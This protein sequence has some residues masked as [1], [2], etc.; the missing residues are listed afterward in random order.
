LVGIDGGIARPDQGYD[1][2]QVDGVVYQP[3]ETIGGICQHNSIKK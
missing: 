2:R 3:C 1:I